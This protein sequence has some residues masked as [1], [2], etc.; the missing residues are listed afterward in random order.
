MEVKGKADLGDVD[1]GKLSVKTDDGHTKT[2]V[3]SE[4]RTVKVEGAYFGT[5]GAM[6]LG[7]E[8][9]TYKFEVEKIS[10]LAGNCASS[11]AAR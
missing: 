3:S 10:R 8:I 7:A 6:K 11:G 2:E 1:K 5:P 9:P 4:R